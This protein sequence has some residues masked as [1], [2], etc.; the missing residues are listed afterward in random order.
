[1]GLV[2]AMDRQSVVVII[3]G[4][5]A[6][7]VVAIPLV[8]TSPVTMKRVLIGAIVVAFILAVVPAF[9]RVKPVSAEGLRFVQPVGLVKACDSFQGTGTI[10]NGYELLV[11]DRA[12][13]GAF[14]LDGTAIRTAAGWSTPSISLGAPQVE[15][16]AVLVPAGFVPYLR[17]IK[18]F[19][20]EG[21]PTDE[22]SWKSDSLPPGDQVD[23]AIIVEPNPSDTQYC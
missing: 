2:L 21:T 1:M 23:P 20:R 9:V 12:V 6:A 16:A 11:F 15:I 13:G 18:L 10:P 3:M 8:I 14:Y 22:A 7:L 5:L 19:D 17:S 4:I